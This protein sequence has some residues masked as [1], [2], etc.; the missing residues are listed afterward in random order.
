MDHLGSE[1]YPRRKTSRDW[2]HLCLSLALV[3]TV[4]KA[5]GELPVLWAA[6][7]VM[8]GLLPT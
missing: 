2:R 5:E 3:R 1:S 7:G 4:V 6:G 8:D